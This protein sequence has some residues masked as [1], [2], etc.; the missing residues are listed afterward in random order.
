[1]DRRGPA[2]GRHSSESRSILAVVSDEWGV[3]QI[4]VN[5]SL[6]GLYKLGSVTRALAF[7]TLVVIDALPGYGVSEVFSM[8]IHER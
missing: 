2:D 7:V 8:F 1:M 3:M 5:T 6:R 4:G